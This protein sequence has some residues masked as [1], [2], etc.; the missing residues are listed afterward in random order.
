MSLFASEY[1]LQ[2]KTIMKKLFVLLILAAVSLNTMAQR[3]VLS[4][5]VSNEKTGERIAQANISVDNTDVAVVTNDDGFFS[6]KVD[7]LPVD[8]TISR[9]GY[10]SEH[11]RLQTDK[12]HNLDIRLSPKAIALPEVVVWTEDPREL[13]NIAIEKIPDNYSQSPELHKCFYRETAMKR[14]HYIYVAEGV[15][16]MYKTGYNQGIRRDRV[17]I[18]KG[19]RLLSPKQSDTLGVKV[20]GGPM[21]PVQLDIVK[22]LD[23]LLNDKELDNYAFTLLPHATI[24]DRLQFVVGLTPNTTQ[25]YALFVGKLYIDCETL[26]FTRA[27][28]TLDMSNPAKATL[29]MLYKKPFGV[30]FKPRELS[31]LVDYKQENGVTHI[32]YV[33]NTFRFNCDWKRR[34]FATSFAAFCEMVVTDRTSSDVAPISGRDSFNSRDTFYDQVE[35]FLD[36]DFWEDYNIIEPTESLDRAIDKLVKKHK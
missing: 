14:Q 6:L 7:Q 29:Y 36:P 4:G 27:E 1:G 5:T 11:L 15:M 12:I 8:I 34:L 13:V 2:K 24:N 23:F 20:L 19:R 30:R 25:P 9:L 17:A 18:I 10:R 3:T 28:L 26:A 35:Y 33:R 16:D 32:S 22:N 21:L 31:L